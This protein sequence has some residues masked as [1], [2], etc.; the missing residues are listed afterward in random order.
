[1]DKQ[2]L[3]DYF[4]NVAILTSKLSHCVSHKVGAC[5]VY[6]SRIISTGYNGTAKDQHNCDEIYKAE[7]MKNPDMRT[8]HHEFSLREEIHAEL[9]AIIDAG[10]RGTLIE[11]STLY[12]TLQPCENC[13][14]LV[15]GAGI[16]RVV[17]K[18]FYDLGDK[19]G[20]EF[21]EKSGVEV[22]QQSG[23]L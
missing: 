12:V 15:L 14:K 16:K 10:K 19:K 5:L 21:L 11:D 22:V 13:A 7:D 8:S 9:N 18:D 3:D 17:F 23:T 6:N 1:M 2:K 20:I 4:M